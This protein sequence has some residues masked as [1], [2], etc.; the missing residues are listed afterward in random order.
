MESI[1]ECCYIKNKMSEYSGIIFFEIWG[2]NK[3]FQGLLQVR[4]Y[5]SCRTWVE[6]LQQEKMETPEI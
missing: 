5:T 4:V 6:V 3:E 2:H 1:Y